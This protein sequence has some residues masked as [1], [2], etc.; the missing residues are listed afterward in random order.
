MARAGTALLPQEFPD[1]VRVIV[2]ADVRL[3]TPKGAVV[4]AE[5]AKDRP[6]GSDEQLHGLVKGP[7]AFRPRTPPAAALE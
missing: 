3:V 6:A 7:E 5:R 1:V 4:L 2:E